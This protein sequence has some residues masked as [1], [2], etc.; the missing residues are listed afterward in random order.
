L[1]SARARFLEILAEARSNR[2]EMGT[3][4]DIFERFVDP[5]KPREQIKEVL[6]T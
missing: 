3:G 5:L 2:T 4:A 1:P 6:V